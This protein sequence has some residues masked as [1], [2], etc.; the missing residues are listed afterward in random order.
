[1]KFKLIIFLFICLPVLASTG[2][3]PLRQLAQNTLPTIFIRIDD[4]FSD[5]KETTIH[6]REDF[7]VP[8]DGAVQYESTLIH[9]GRKL[10][11]RIIKTTYYAY[12][13][14]TDFHKTRTRT[15]RIPQERADRMIA[16]LI[17]VAGRLAYI[18]ECYPMPH[19]LSI[20]RATSWATDDPQKGLLLLSHSNNDM[21]DAQ[22]KCKAYRLLSQSEPTKRIQAKYEMYRRSEQYEARKK[23]LIDFELTDNWDS[24]E[25]T[26][27]KNQAA[28]A[29]AAALKLQKSYR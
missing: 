6:M 22:E 28:I 9:Q 25:T 27:K 11:S 29:R 5:S 18:D 14:G 21:R 16:A 26:Q 10:R 20:P 17:G 12:P 23:R 4:R 3:K 1:M 7:K 24:I 19:N 8:Y 13:E 2:S 15:K